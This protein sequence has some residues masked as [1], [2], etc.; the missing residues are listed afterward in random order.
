MVITLAI[1]YGLRSCYY[2]TRMVVDGAYY[3]YYGKQVTKEEKILKEL[4]EIKNDN[5]MRE[6][7]ILNEIQDLKQ[8]NL[9]FQDKLQKL[10]DKNFLDKQSTEYLLL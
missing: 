10:L 3:L 7:K 8:K 4:D 2:L 6:E 9:E 1:D 5:N